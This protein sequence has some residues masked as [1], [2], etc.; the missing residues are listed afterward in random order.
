MLLRS[1]FSSA[2]LII[3]LHSL[4]QTINTESS[5]V[6]FSVSNMKFNTVEGYFTGM[7]G[8][9]N[10]NSE[11]LATSSFDVCIDANTV[12]TGNE[13]RDTH[14]KNEDFFE[15][16][17]YPE[18]CFTSTS[19]EKTESGYKALGSLTMHGVSKAAE[20][21]F[22]QNGKELVGEISVKRY[23][24]SIGPDT[25]TFMVGNEIKVYILCMLN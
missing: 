23:D 2:L 17:T 11:E 20:I 4:S 13:K 1:F 25:G 5:K 24:Y 8:T 18:I 19:I 10:F 3:C 7:K 6:T 9:L 14:L 16:G 15:V 21:P 22:S 12:N